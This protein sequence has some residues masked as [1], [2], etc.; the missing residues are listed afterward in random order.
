M[1][2]LDSEQND[3]MTTERVKA[4]KRGDTCKKKRRKTTNSFQEKNGCFDLRESAEK[5]GKKMG[6]LE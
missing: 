4:D 6:W 3:K 1:L 5:E 2:V